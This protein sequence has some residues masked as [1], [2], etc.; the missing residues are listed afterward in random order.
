MSFASLLEAGA[1]G[2]GSSLVGGSSSKCGC[3]YPLSFK[4]SWSSQF[5]GRLGSLVLTGARSLRFI[6]YGFAAFHH[7]AH[8]VQDHVDIRQRIAFDGN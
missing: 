2:L 6:H 3:L 7:P 8:V 1:E 4:A 5:S